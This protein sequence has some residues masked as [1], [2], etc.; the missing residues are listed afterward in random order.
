MIPC[1][2]MAIFVPDETKDLVVGR[3]CRR[4]PRVEAASVLRVTR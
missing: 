3:F 2:S 1:T 4:R